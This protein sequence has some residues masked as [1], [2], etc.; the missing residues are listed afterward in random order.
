MELKVTELT[1]GIVTP[2]LYI[3]PTIQRNHFALTAG[4]G[5]VEVVQLREIVA[6]DV[7]AGR[8]QA[9]SST[10]ATASSTLAVTSI[11]DDMRQLELELHDDMTATKDTTHTH[12]NTPS[13]SPVKPVA[14]G[15]DKSG[16]KVSKRAKRI[17][18]E[19]EAERIIRDALLDKVDHSDS[20]N[21]I[22]IMCVCVMCHSV[23]AVIR[24][25]KKKRRKLK[26]LRPKLRLKLRL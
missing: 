7:T 23:F 16:G 4:R 26:L 9:S 12:T 13:A 10:S 24:I 18:K 2:L 15:K 3:F 17:A 20:I 14:M 1:G 5:R 6:N 19:E 8:G 25:E 21:T 11:D 22:T